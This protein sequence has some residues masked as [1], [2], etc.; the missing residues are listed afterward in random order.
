MSN[1]FVFYSSFYEALA[2]LDDADR[3]EAYDAICRYSL[4]GEE[5][6][7][8]GIVRAIFLLVRPVID[9]NA[10]RRENGKKGGE[11]G[12]LGGRPRK[13]PIGVIDE[14][15][16]GVT[17][18]NPTK[19]PDVDVDEDIDVDIKRESVGKRKP[20]RHKYGMYQNVLLSDDQIEKLKAE[21]PDYQAYIE[22]VSEYVAKTGRGYKD[23][24]AAIRSWV[25]RD[26]EHKRSEAKVVNIERNNSFN[27][28]PQREDY[29]FDELGRLLNGKTV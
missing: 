26:A 2:E 16:I 24:L 18:E 8:S 15:P 23:Y 22:K 7:V 20:E 12:T 1:S 29:D 9:A 10:E 21:I 5:P 11:F 4:V 6:N 13:N 17:T 28:F 25:R 14:N 19:T 3:L 27:N